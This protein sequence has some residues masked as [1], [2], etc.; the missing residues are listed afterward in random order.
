[1]LI[2]YC[3]ATGELKGRVCYIFTSLFCM[4]K[5]E[6]LRNKE[7]CFLFHFESSFSSWDNQILIFQIFHSHEVIK[8]LSIKHETH[9]IE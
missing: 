4:P 8:C 9:F 5:R 3:L 2:L 6:D 7:K 1:M